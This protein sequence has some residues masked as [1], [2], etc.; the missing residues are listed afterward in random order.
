MQTT[1]FKIQAVKTKR[2]PRYPSFNERVDVNRAQRRLFSP[3]TIALAGIGTLG[4]AAS[5]PG[6]EEEIGNKKIDQKK[7][8]ALVLATLDSYPKEKPRTPA[9]NA[10]ERTTYQNKPSS[11]KENPDL[12]AVV[13]IVNWK[14]STSGKVA[15]EILEVKK[16][17][18]A[19]FKLF[20]LYGV[21]LKKDQ[22]VQGKDISFEADASNPVTKFMSE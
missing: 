18:E 22:M 20:E 21:N 17:R 1:I 11:V 9:Q 7:V 16:A 3:L 8:A 13:K 10:V 19:T 6:A 5:A 12:T 4:M 15:Q 2:Q 14:G